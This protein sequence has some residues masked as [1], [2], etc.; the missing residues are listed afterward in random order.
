[1]W[2]KFIIRKHCTVRIFWMANNR[3]SEK[4]LLIWCIFLLHVL[5]KWVR[6]SLSY[7]ILWMFRRS[8]MKFYSDIMLSHSMNIDIQ[9]SSCAING[10][11]YCIT[12]ITISCG[13]IHIV[14]RTH[15]GPLWAPKQPHTLYYARNAWLR[16]WI[17][18]CF[19]RKRLS[20]QSQCV[21]MI[22]AELFVW[23]VHELHITMHAFHE[24]WRIKNLN[25]Q[26]HVVHKWISN[27]SNSESDGCGFDGANSG[28]GSHSRICYAWW[29]YTQHPME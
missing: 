9:C 12:V 21:E 6:F 1:M 4:L 15:W 23:S 14:L 29:I 10:S 28:L 22:N 17:R 25:K 11:A 8:S 13:I 26:K 20:L 7:F 18:L 5:A 19:R 2:Q 24:W 3:L 27:L 16:Y